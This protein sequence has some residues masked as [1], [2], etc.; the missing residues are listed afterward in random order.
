M[1]RRFAL[2]ALALASSIGFLLG[3]DAAR[4]L[5]IESG[6]TPF[7]SPRPQPAVTGTLRTPTD[8]VETAARVNP[9][10]V[11]IEAASRGRASGRGD[12]RDRRPLV[13]DDVDDPHQDA[14][15]NAPREGSG[16][17]FVIEADGHILTN[18]HVIHAAERILVTLADGRAL[19]AHVV[20]TDPA[21]DIA[22]LKVNAG[23]P[24]PVAALGDSSR[25][26]VGEWVCA[27]GNPLDYEHSVTVG[28][29]SSLG[30]KL[31]DESLDDYIQTDAAI[32]FGNSGGP[33]IN[34]RGEVI[35]VNAAISWRASSIGFAIPIN[36]VR[37]VLPQL[38]VR[39]RVARGYVG[40]TLTELDPDLARS[41]RLERTD[42]ALVQDVTSGSP[43]E[44]AGLRPYDLIR[45]VDGQ[46]VRTD[47]DLIRRISARAP[48]SVVDITLVR[49]GR[50]QAVSLRLAERPAAEGPAAA[51]A[52]APRRAPRP[53]SPALWAAELLGATVRELDPRSARQLELPA[54]L[55]GV[56]ILDV[57]PM[58]PAD[59][60]GLAHGD[61]VLE[62]NRQAVRGLD[63]YLRAVGGARAGDVL[64]FYCYVPEARQRILRPVRVEPWPE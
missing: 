24:L 30:R 13:P 31:F 20:G 55:R 8:F 51:P 28:V 4:W 27:I 46:P 41:L 59:E 5:G 23:N 33:L 10:V 6:Q 50:E 34:A 29:V 22:L 45:S 36:V 44:R 49:D 26:R 21:T 18:Y 57:E 60:A 3:V 53:A 40:V 19:R 47:D 35:G 58:G 54:G 2:F 15:P 12:G 56:V 32:N 52:R 17:G 11:G 7:V 62:V 42:G 64:A 25:L 63:D 37:A 61:I 9:A 39:G 48:G 16:S 1:S 43:G 38:K 14:D